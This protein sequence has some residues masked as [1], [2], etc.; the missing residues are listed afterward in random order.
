MRVNPTIHVLCKLTS[1]APSPA[2]PSDSVFS[3]VF[4]SLSLPFS[5]PTH[6]LASRSLPPGAP[7]RPAPIAGVQASHP[8]APSAN[9]PIIGFNPSSNP[10]PVPR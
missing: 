1:W 3:L 7:A 9:D 10:L 6:P 5:E 4:L 8:P 2:V